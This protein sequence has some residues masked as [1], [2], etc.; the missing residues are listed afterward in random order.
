MLKTFSF[1]LQLKHFECFLSIKFSSEEL[2]HPFTEIVISYLK[3]FRGDNFL[4]TNVFL[5]SVKND[6][7]VEIHSSYVV[8]RSVKIQQQ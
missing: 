8:A 2:K 5:M 1:S 4:L 3:T 7:T 6:C